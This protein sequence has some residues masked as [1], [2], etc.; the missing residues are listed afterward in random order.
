MLPLLIAQAL[1]GA[2]LAASFSR[3]YE[4]RLVLLTGFLSG[5]IPAIDALYRFSGPPVDRLA[6]A[7][8]ITY[9]FFFIPFGAL[10]SATAVFALRRLMESER[11]LRWR[12]RREPRYSSGRVL[13]SRQFEIYSDTK[14]PPVGPPL[15]F[16]R[17]YRFALLGMLAPGLYRA[18]GAEGSALFWPFSDARIARNLFHAFDPVVLFLLGSGILFALLLR[19]KKPARW[20]VM[21]LMLYA[22]LAMLQHDRAERALRVFAAERNH[23]VSALEVLPTWGNINLKRGLY[24]RTEGNIYICAINLPV[25]GRARI[26]AGPEFAPLDPDRYFPGLPAEHRAGRQLKA[27]I[28][29][30]RGFA[31]LVEYHET[32]HASDLR[33]S[34]LPHSGIPEVLLQLPARG[35]RP[36][37]RA[38]LALR[39]HKESSPLFRLAFFRQWMGQ[40]LPE[41]VPD[42]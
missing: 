22:A 11:V 8:W 39:R 33:R 3:S 7:G 21:A 23:H 18:L 6:Q 27:F 20:G 15:T 10:L 29:A 31:A 32:P 37:E 16:P 4:I 9:S 36:P 28:E 2:G 14:L 34:P 19:D 42:A 5:L 35:E 40:D 12:G 30:A 13:V 17:L 26:Y 38:R 41:G 24:R 25:I 1:L